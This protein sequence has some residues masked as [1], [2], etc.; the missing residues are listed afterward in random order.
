MTSYE[1]Y[2]GH[3]KCPKC[4]SSNTGT[5][6]IA[7]SKKHMWFVCHDCEWTFKRAASSVSSLSR[8]LSRMAKGLS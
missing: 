3:H 5:D 8:H 4:D 7:T 2:L 1:C 6:C